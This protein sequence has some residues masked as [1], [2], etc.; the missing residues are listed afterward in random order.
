MSSSVRVE[1]QV[2]SSRS[3]RSAPAASAA[4]RGRTLLYSVIAVLAFLYAMP[5]VWMISTSLKPADQ[6]YLM[7]PVWI[8]E[9]W[10]WSNYIDALVRHAVPPLLPQHDHGHV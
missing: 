9:T 1:A 7:P 8:P 3:R 2:R 4:T 10:N 5:F 6:V